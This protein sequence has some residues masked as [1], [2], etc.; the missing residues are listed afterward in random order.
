MSILND[1]GM[2]FVS[3][4]FK[5]ASCKALRSG[6]TGTATVMVQAP[7][8]AGDGFIFNSKAYDEE[9]TSAGDSSGAEGNASLAS[10]P[11]RVGIQWHEN[12]TYIPD[13]MQISKSE[14]Q[15][16]TKTQTK[17]K[18]IG[19]APEEME[20]M[21]GGNDC[22]INIPAFIDNITCLKTVEC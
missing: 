18:M 11:Y 22:D 3:G 21:I 10:A 13:K 7:K 9:S 17:L 20:I 19:M 15:S 4:V 8:P 1:V 6:L 14:T 5:H 16:K 2:L 12:T